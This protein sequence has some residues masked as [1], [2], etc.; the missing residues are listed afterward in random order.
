MVLEL[1]VAFFR[2]LVP[3]GLFFGGLGLLVFILLPILSIVTGKKT[4]A[5]VH[6]W[7]FMWIYQRAALV[8]SEHGD[9]IAKQMEFDDVGVEKISFDDDVKEFN[10]PA[11]ALSSWM[12]FPF[13]LANEEFGLLFDP[14]HAA[15]AEKKRDYDERGLKPIKCLS[16]LRNYGVEEWG[17]GVFEI[18]DR[19]KAWDMTALPAIVDGGER[20]EYPARVEELYRLSRNPFSSSKPMLK[21]L[22]PVAAFIAVFVAMWQIGGSTDATM[23]TSAVSFGLLWLLVAAPE[24]DLGRLKSAMLWV[25]IGITPVALFGLLVVAT[26]PIFAVLAAIMF[27]VGIMSL[28]MFTLV[29][30]AS[31]ILSKLLGQMVY[32]KLGLLPYDQPLLEWTPRGYRMREL[33][34]LDH[35]DDADM[36]WFSLAGSQIGFTFPPTP[37]AFGPET[38]SHDRLEAH[39]EDTVTDGGEE[40]DPTPPGY[41]RSTLT[42]DVF[43]GYVPKRL[44]QDAFYL[45]SGIALSRF[46]DA[47][48]GMKSLKRLL[49]AKEE[50]GA[51][52]FGI[53]DRTLLWAT[54][55]SVVLAAGL[56]VLIFFL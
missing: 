43:G 40:T 20:A 36:S 3:Y 5:N 22:V 11:A 4:F 38:I 54:M 53:S 13:A 28:P 14:R 21:L 29:A 23:S 51:G 2:F 48:M 1:L 46:T 6:L 39:R 19:Y 7:L 18:P 42:R 16:D 12:G 32:L 27:V 34:A 17:P 26:T 30:R 37:D 45:H 50:Y 8:F 33:D 55:A 10:D 35:V 44:N 25:V 31:N 49:Y 9:V 56:G 15:I 52:D 24:L 41:A 47:A